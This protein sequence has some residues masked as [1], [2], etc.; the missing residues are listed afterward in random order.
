MLSDFKVGDWI[1][2][3]VPKSDRYHI[4]EILEEP[5]VD[6]IWYKLLFHATIY[7]TTNTYTKAEEHLQ[8]YWNSDNRFILP[9]KPTIEEV[10]KIKQTQEKE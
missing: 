1:K 4:G 3:K 8:G 6:S 5:K 10:F 9:Y 7:E 2:F